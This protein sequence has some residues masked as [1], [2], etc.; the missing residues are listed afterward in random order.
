MRQSSMMGALLLAGAT[1]AVASSPK[2]AQTNTQ[3]AVDP[4]DQV[5]YGEH[6]NNRANA[7]RARQIAKATLRASSKAR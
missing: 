6:E 5:G 4:R 7:R 1:A 2:K 3:A